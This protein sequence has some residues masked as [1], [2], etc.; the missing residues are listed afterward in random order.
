MGLHHTIPKDLGNPTKKP[1]QDAFVKILRD[2][3]AVADKHKQKVIY[4][5]GDEGTNDGSE[6]K[7][8]EIGKLTKT[9]MNDLN[10]MSD[11][12]GYR[13]LVGMAP[14]LDACGFNRGWEGGYGT[15]R[16]RQLMTRDV[17]ERVRKLGAQPWFINGGKGRYAFGMWF[18]KT[19]KWGQYGKIEWHF[20]ASSSDP[21]NPFDGTSP[22]DFGSLVLPDQV[23]TIQ[24]EQCREGIDDLRYLQ[25]LE[26]LVAENADSKDPYLRNVVQR[27]QEALTLYNDLVP[28]RFDSRA[29]SDGAGVYTGLYWTQGRLDKM[30]K[31]I[32]ML[33]CMFKGAVIPGIYGDFVIAD[34]DTG[35]RPGRH[36]SSSIVEHVKDPEHATQGEHCFKFTFKG[37]KG[38]GGRWG[39]PLPQRTGAAIARSSL[40]SSTRRRRTSRSF[41]TCATSWPPTQGISNSDTGRSSTASR[42]RTPSTST[43]SESKRPAAITFSTCRVFSTSSSSRRRRRIRRFTSTT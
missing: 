32:A 38:Y 21:F 25:H 30:R 5:I 35:S 28:D 3:Q 17:I 40:T 36:I 8:I 37:G 20:D 1:W 19:T 18:W 6:A 4:S 7:I 29:T 11:I 22:N 9:R 42:A 10:F 14:Y 34:G 39:A 43:S 15:N 33:I 2:Y 12:N 16:T 41:S 26:K 23:C 13:E 31:E 27:A 24:F